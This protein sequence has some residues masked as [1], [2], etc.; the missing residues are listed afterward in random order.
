MLTF[1][2]GLRPTIQQVCADLSQS[3]DTQ[4]EH[5]IQSPAPLLQM[6]TE[7]L[8]SQISAPLHQEVQE[9]LDYGTMKPL[10]MR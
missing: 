4:P 10:C 9:W 8:P 5:P 3:E 7:T 2:E 6:E 1:E